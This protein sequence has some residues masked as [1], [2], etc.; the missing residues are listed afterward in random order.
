MSQREHFDKTALSCISYLESFPECR[1]VNFSCGEG[2]SHEA[3][4]WEKR[5]KQK[6]PQDLKN[7]YSLFNGVQLGWNAD[8]SE[9]VQVGLIRVNRLEGLQPVAVEGVL[10]VLQLSASAYASP[11]ASASEV[12][13]VG[14]VGGEG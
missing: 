13:G 10:G 7:F 12:G 3:L 9:S 14:G 5:H 6:L 2:A 11:S 8:L 4:L 1:N